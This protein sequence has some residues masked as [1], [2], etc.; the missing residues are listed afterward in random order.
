MSGLYQPHKWKLHEVSMQQQDKNFGPGVL[1]LSGCKGLQSD[2]G[3]E[4][5]GLT[6]SSRHST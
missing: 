1:A 4:L 2:M 5:G 3:V 6:D